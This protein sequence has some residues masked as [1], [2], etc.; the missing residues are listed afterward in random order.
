[1][2][3]LEKKQKNQKIKNEAIRIFN[4]MIAHLENTNLLFDDFFNDFGYI[5][6]SVAKR[7]EAQSK[8]NSNDFNLRFDDIT[9]NQ[10]INEAML[11]LGYSDKTR[12]MIP[13]D[14][15]INYR[16]YYFINAIVE[17]F[18]I[19]YCIETD[20]LTGEPCE[21]YL[22]YLDEATIEHLSFL[23]CEKN[24]P[25]EDYYKSLSKAQNIWNSLI[26]PESKSDSRKLNDLSVPKK[27]Y[28][29]FV[30][31]FK[32]P[33]DL[34]KIK[35]V[36]KSKNL[37]NEDGF[38]ISKGVFVQRAIYDYCRT[39]NLLCEIIVNRDIFARLIGIE[40]GKEITGRSLDNIPQNDK[41]EK[42]LKAAFKTKIG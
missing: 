37:L 15:P 9:Y 32:N 14:V 1:M 18:K 25:I 7:P 30:E 19:D 35:D 33:D 20:E 24:L 16:M 41:D 11:L 2:T 42:D 26:I 22:K 5:F 13:Y 3:F 29:T 17:D 10:R 40:F 31:L 38:L 34:Q 6:Q 21:I 4:L 36:L 27:E 12:E 8:I 23:I 39:K 28:A